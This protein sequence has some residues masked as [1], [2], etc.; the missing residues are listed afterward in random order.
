[1]AEDAITDDAQAPEPEV[2]DTPTD[3]VDSA[4]VEDGT[5]ADQPEE[6]ID[7]KKRAE[8][9]QAWATRASQE[10]S[11]LREAQE[12]AEAE[13]AIVEALSD[14]EQ[15]EQTFAYLVQELG[16]EEATAWAEAHGF[17]VDLEDEEGQ[18]VRDPRVDQLLAKEAQK[19]AQQ[20]AQQV[21]KGMEETLD[22][23]LKDKNL[24]R[25]KLPKGVVDLLLDAALAR[26]MQTQ[27]QDVNG[28]LKAVFGQ[29]HTAREAELKAYRQSKRDTPSTPV[30]GSSGTPN[31]SLGDRDERLARANAVAE[32]ALIQP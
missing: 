15:Q 24:S 13:Q 22:A 14:P 10:A 21:E 8:D 18:E 4:P 6:E 23:C 12:A 32:E 25:D 30:P 9:A 29:W 28:A 27:D 17:E 16:Q 5:R 31:P 19:E 11:E 2:Q 1:M 26:G 7:W 3:A 20:F